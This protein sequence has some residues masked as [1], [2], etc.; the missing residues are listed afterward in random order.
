MIPFIFVFLW[1]TGF[2]GAKYALAYIEPFTLL[3]VRMILTLCI[4]LVWAL[5][6]VKHWPSRKQAKHQM[7]IGMLIHGAYLGGVF[8]AIKLGLP[9]GITAIIVG[10]QPVLTALISVFWL[11][12][13]LSY[14]QYLGFAFGLLGVVGTIG[15][16]QGFSDFTFSSAAVLCALIALL[17]IT[18]GSLYQKKQGA[19]V[20]LLAG[21][22]WQYLGCCIIMAILSFGFESQK[23]DWSVTL[24]AALAW[25]IVALSILSILLLMYLIREGEVSKVASYFYLVPIV[26]SIQAWWLFDETLSLPAIVAMG[27]TVYGVYLV[28]SKQNE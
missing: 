2:I 26:A 14:R 20:D 9:A 17:G 15:L 11:H 5:S 23:I 18:I 22:V 8:A 25:L 1:S 13:K 7:C 21:M 28:V 6:R 24:I 27:M 10:V 16:T 19:N 3:L 4:L 12:Q